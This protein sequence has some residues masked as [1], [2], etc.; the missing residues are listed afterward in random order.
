[1]GSAV[2]TI[3]ETEKVHLCS[4]IPPGGSFGDWSRLLHCS[5][6]STN[7]RCKGLGC[8][9]EEGV[10]LEFLLLAVEEVLIYNKDKWIDST[11]KVVLLSATP[12]V[13]KL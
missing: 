1:M 11:L 2:I 3:I 9:I 8:F 12:D 6:G 4:P 5:W 7:C 10:E 13:V